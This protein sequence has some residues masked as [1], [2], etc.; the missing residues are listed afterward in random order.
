MLWCAVNTYINISII[1]CIFIKHIMVRLM[2]QQNWTYILISYN[3]HVYNS[4]TNI[5][6]IVGEFLICGYDWSKI[7]ST[8]KKLT[9]LIIKH[10]N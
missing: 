2:L 9:R 1:I 3:Q 8:C 5:A 10:Y 6:L 7:S 4:Q